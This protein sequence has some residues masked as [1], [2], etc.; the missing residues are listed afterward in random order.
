[1]NKKWLKLASDLMHEA[2]D[3]FSNHGCNDWNYPSSWSLKDKQQFTQA[4]YEANGDLEEYD[5]EHLWLADW[6]VMRFMAR[7]LKEMS[8]PT[9][10]G[11]NNVKK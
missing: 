7:K 8:K 2:A 9:K 5:P 6:Q 4:V 11:K 1:M 10:K 3:E